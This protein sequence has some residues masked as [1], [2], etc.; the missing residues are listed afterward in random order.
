MEINK[1]TY[2]VAIMISAA[3]IGGS[4]VLVQYNKQESIEKQQELKLEAEAQEAEAEAEQDQKKYEAGREKDCL[5]IFKVEDD[6]WNNVKGW[7][8]SSDKDNCYIVYE[9]SYSDKKTDEECDEN[10]PLD[11]SLF[12]NW[13]NNSLCKDG[14]FENSF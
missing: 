4:L 2:P 8:Y 9:Y 7:R 5:A 14:R 12:S 3:L 6:K 1:F 13:R 10:Y 11:G